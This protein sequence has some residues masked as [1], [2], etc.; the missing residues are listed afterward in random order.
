MRD[1]S[2]ERTRFVNDRDAADFTIAGIAEALVPPD[3]NS[4]VDV[5]I[6]GKPVTRPYRRMGIALARIEGGTT[7]EAR[8]VAAAAAGKLKINYEG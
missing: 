6:F 1:H 4:H 3:A 5:R 2:A 8:A 7:D